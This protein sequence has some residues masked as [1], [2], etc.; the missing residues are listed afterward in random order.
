MS[1]YKIQRWD[2]VFIENNEHPIPMIYIKP[3]ATFLAFAEEN[4][5]A[6]LV[7]IEGT[8]TLYDGKDIV[9]VVS[10]SAYVPNLR[11]NYFNNTGLWVVKLSAEWIEYP[12]ST[13]GTATFSGSN[14]PKKPA[15]QIPN[16]PIKQPFPGKPLR[17]PVDNSLLKPVSESVNE[18]YMDD[19]SKDNKS[20]L[21]SNQITY[22]L[23][24]TVSIFAVL[25]WM[26]KKEHKE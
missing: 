24:A 6:V 26:A 20:N 19:K 9:G 12:Q 16:G 8:G 15:K 5:W 18:N 11:I 2:P 14:A 25:L 7:R 23:V 4:H 17:E 10:Q 21:D 3:D 22:I 1:K 13:L